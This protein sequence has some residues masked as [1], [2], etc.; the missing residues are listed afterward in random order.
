MALAA[1]FVLPLQAQD[2]PATA[3]A[4]G[5]PDT[6][7]GTVQSPPSSPTNEAPSAELIIDAE[8]AVTKDPV[9]APGEEPLPAMDN[10]LP[11]EEN[12][13]GADL[14]G[15]TPSYT[16]SPEAQIPERPPLVEDPREAERKQRVQ[17]R[18][19]KA[20][21]ER[22]PQ[23]V[24]LAEDAAAARTPEGYRAAR[25]AYYT[26]FF[27]KVRKAD[28]SLATY[29]NNLEKTTIAELYQKRVEPTMPLEPPP[30]PQPA[31]ALVPPP[32][33]PPAEGGDVPLP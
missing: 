20:S 5:T 9:L 23:M 32:E 4:T 1:A 31:P 30:E 21:V 2:V 14:F 6:Q 12:I 24:Q 18:K 3:E 10:K 15:A 8:Q 11:G 22:D 27:S 25:R 29:C 17:F 26:V 13:F 19:I 16:P 28:S 33:F 7:S